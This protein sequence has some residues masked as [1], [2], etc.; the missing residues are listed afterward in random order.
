MKVFTLLLIL[1]MVPPPTE[2]ALL[3]PGTPPKEIRKQSGHKIPIYDSVTASVRLP[4]GTVSTL[5]YRTGSGIREKSFV[6]FSV[7]AYFASHYMDTPDGFRGKEALSAIAKSRVHAI[8]LTFLR[9]IP[10]C[11]LYTSPSPRD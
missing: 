1:A 6:L 2:A 3:S 5:L 4:N 7:N 9:S 10:A 8:Q 11:L